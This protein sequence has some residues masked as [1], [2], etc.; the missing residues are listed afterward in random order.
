MTKYPRAKETKHI[1]SIMNYTDHYHAQDLRKIGFI[2]ID[3]KIFKLRLVE[4]IHL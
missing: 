3:F 1:C 4:N 2:N